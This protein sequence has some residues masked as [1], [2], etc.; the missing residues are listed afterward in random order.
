MSEI[1]TIDARE[2]RILSEE[3]VAV[4]Q[5]AMDKHGLA[6]SYTGGRYGGPTATL[7]FKLDVPAIAEKVANKDGELVGAKFSVGHVFESNGYQYKVTGF[8]L[9]RPKYPVSAE[10]ASNGKGYKFPVEAVNRQIELAEMF[11]K[12]DVG[13]F[14]YP[15][16]REE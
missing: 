7:S 2:C 10:R 9:R 16:G 14:M 5:Q 11:N 6:V 8:N 3:L 13:G 4:I 12:S 1:K 15:K